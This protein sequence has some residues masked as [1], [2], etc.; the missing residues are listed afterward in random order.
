MGLVLGI[1]LV[2]WS[3]GMLLRL[4]RQLRWGMIAGLYLAVL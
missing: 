4:T 3:V 2:L 1:A